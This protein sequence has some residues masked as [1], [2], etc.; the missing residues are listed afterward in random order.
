MIDSG[1]NTNYLWDLAT[2]E[3]EQTGA[4]AVHAKTLSMQTH[5]LSQQGAHQ[6][7]GC[8]LSQCL[9]TTWLHTAWL[10]SELILFFHTGERIKTWLLQ[11]KSNILSEQRC[12][13]EAT[14]FAGCDV[15]SQQQRF[16]SGQ[17]LKA[18]FS[19]PRLKWIKI[20]L[21]W[22]FFKPS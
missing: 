14:L 13:A 2:A 5:I 18:F 12:D 15:H 6:G 21:F 1:L 9:T 8:I 16:N 17:L 11:N 7:R 10:Y 19:L 22:G 4:A 3:H 20:S